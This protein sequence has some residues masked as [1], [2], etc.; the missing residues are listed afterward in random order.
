MTVILRTLTNLLFLVPLAVARYRRAHPAERVLFAGA[1]KAVQRPS[2]EEPRRGFHWSFA[3]RGSLILTDSHLVFRSAFG[4][5]SLRLPLGEI[6]R[7]GLI[8]FRSFLLAG[9][10]LKVSTRDGAHYQFGMADDP[11]WAEQAALPCAREAGRVRHTPV[12][13]AL[14]LALVAWLVYLWWTRQL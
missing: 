6:E 12:T 2:D 11:A 4:A 10:L 9:L 7:A 3:L 14:R 5:G 1:A 8:A 13:V